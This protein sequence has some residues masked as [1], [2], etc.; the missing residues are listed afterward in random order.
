MDRGPL[1]EVREDASELAW[2][3]FDACSEAV[4]ARARA[5]RREVPRRSS[6]LHRVTL[7][8]DDVM[9]TARL[10]DRVCPVPEVWGRIHRMLRGLRA[11]Q[12]GDPPPP[13]V[14]VLEWA[15]TSEFLKRLRLREQVEWARRHGALV[16]L[17]AFLR[18]L[19]ERDWHHVEV[20]AW[21]TLPRR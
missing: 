18:R 17:D 1:P 14:D 19:P 5:R 15:R 10:N 16:A 20:A 21:P 11:A 3:E 12:D 6:K 4:E 7:Q 9:Q 8:V 13:P 2:R